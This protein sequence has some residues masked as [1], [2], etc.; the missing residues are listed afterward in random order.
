MKIGVIVDNE[1]DNDHRVQKQIKQLLLAGHSIFVLCL[2]FGSTYKKYTEITVARIPI[3]QTF[4]NVLVM[5]STR[6]SFYENLWAQ[7]ISKFI[8]TYQLEALHSHDLYMAKASRDGIN[9]SNPSASLTIDLHENY[10]AAINSY[11]WATKGWRQLV[12]SPKKW[13]NKE[14]EYL[15]YSDH[16]ITLSESFKQDLL[17]RFPELQLKKIE[18]HPNFPDFKSFK[19]FENSSVEINFSSTIPTLFYFGVVAKRRGIIDLLPWL[20][21]LLNNGYT[22]HLLIIGPVDKADKEVFTNYLKLKLLQKNSTYLPW[23][24]ISLLP[25]YLKQIDIGLAPFEV[26][27][28]HDSGVANKLYQ[29]MYG[30]IPILATECKAQKE[31]IHNSN[32]GLT[33]SNYTTFKIQL[34]KL[35]ESKEYREQ[36]GSNGKKELLQLYKSEA[37]QKFLKLYAI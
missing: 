18:V 17:I 2:D 31:L 9:N 22:F 11:Q 30:A 8:K 4:K 26:N 10:P 3:S 12:V 35:L 23:A 7:H 29:Y 32:C 6:F 34:K 14:L 37:D 28:Q 27:P 21:K 16:I 25:A 33:Y 15:R 24:D 1:F 13:F 19:L 5:L 36:L 20:E